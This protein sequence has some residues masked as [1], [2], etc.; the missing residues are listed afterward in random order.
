[1]RE[2]KTIKHVTD[3]QSMLCTTRKYIQV[4]LEILRESEKEQAK[5]RCSSRLAQLAK[6]YDVMESFSHEL[7]TSE[8]E[9]LLH[10]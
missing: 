2:V 10:I 9:N 6:Q 7:L 4:H 1:M 5:E 3:V 8:D